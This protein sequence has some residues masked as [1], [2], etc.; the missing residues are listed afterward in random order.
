[1][2]QLFQYL[3]SFLLWA[4]LATILGFF[5]NVG[6]KM[7]DKAMNYQPKKQPGPYANK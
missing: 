1:M 2:K 5:G 3:T 6:I 4:V 7:A